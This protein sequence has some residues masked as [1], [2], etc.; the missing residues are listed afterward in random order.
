[1]SIS[2]PSIGHPIGAVDAGAGRRRGLARVVL[3]GFVVAA[4]RGRGL[5]AHR[6]PTA[7]GSARWTCGPTP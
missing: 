2:N 7:P 6:G 4:R 5:L 1:M 3:V